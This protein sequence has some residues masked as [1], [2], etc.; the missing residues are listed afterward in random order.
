[1]N[2][3]KKIKI[4]PAKLPLRNS[5]LNVSLK[6]FHGEISKSP[7]DHF[8]VMVNNAIVAGMNPK[9]PSPAPINNSQRRL[10]HTSRVTHSLVCCK[11]FPIM[12]VSC[13]SSF[14]WSRAFPKRVRNH[15]VRPCI[16]E[17]PRISSMYGSC[18]S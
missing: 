14:I 5:F 6:I 7:I 9:T 2:S 8:L 16:E 17:I 11:R 12:I 3:P 15:Y 13:L 1:M 18:S 10:T 4:T